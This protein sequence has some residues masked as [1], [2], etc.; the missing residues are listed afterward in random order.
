M[1]GQRALVGM[2][3][4]VRTGCIPTCTLC[5]PTQPRMLTQMA[6]HLYHAATDLNA[7][8]NPHLTKPIRVRQSV[9]RPGPEEYASH[10]W[11]SGVACAAAHP[12]ASLR[13]P[14]ASPGWLMR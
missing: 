10:S 12:S 2:R 14:F 13:A 9:S 7:Y 4:G 3:L 11:T 8:V 1:F 6:W 5:L